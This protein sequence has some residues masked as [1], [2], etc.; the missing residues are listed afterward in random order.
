M[1]HH[2]AGKLGRGRLLPTKFA[3]GGRADIGAL[4]H[5]F[6]TQSGRAPPFRRKAWRPLQL[7]PKSDGCGKALS[8][9]AWRNS[10]YPDESAP[11]L[12]LVAEPGVLGDG[13]DPNFGLFETPP[14]GF[15]PYR[16]HGLCW[17][18]APLFCTKLRVPRLYRASSG[19]IC[20]L[21]RTP[22]M[23]EIRARNP[24]GWYR[25]LG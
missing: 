1:N 20:S 13:L 4:G 11:H 9:L 2:C 18:T 25:R 15:C 22:S 5:F 3:C 17:S 6:A 21:R 12:L 14:C 23:N 7:M 16:L 8:I 10:R 24:A 19:Q